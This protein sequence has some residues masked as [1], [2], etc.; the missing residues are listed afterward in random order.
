MC[1][2]NYPPEFFGDSGSF[3][4]II[5]TFPREDT[6]SWDETKADCFSRGGDDISWIGDHKVCTQTNRY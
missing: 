6:R 1:G 3:V 4:K 5:H 2:N